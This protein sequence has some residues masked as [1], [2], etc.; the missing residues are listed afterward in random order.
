MENRQLVIIGAGPAGLTAAIYGRRAG[1]GVL[2]LERG[3]SGGQINVTAEIENYPG[4]KHAEGMELANAFRE[5]A[6]KF[7]AEFRDC[8]V[9]SV[10]IDGDVKT[11]KTNEGDIEADA[12]IIASGASF[13][14]AGC[15]GERE[16]AG[17][18]VSY[19][20]VCDGAFYE[21]APV[22][23]IGGGN[24]ALDEADFLT[25]FASKVY[26]IHRREE[27]RAHK[28]AVDLAA[29][30]PKI[31]RVMGFI[32]DEIAG[33]DMVERVVARN[34]KSGEIREIEVKGVFVFV[35]TS[36]NTEFLNGDKS[37]ERARGG[38]IVTDNKME[39]SAEGVFAAGDVRDKFLR[40]V[41]TA[42]GDGATAGMAAYEYIFHQHRLKS[43]L[44]APE[45]VTAFFMSSI[46][47]EHLAI[48]SQIDS[49]EK[50]GEEKIVIVDAHRNLRIRKKLDIKVLPVVVE[51]SRGTKVREAVVKTF[52][53]IINF[54]EKH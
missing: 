33:G 27:F 42:A 16:F 18:G 21:D 7:G 40:Q 54:R 19:C 15:K 37:I 22:A 50:S 35:G 6:E 36:P 4:F 39:T 34:L 12:L 46:D 14:R 5:H 43:T 41:V 26:I 13:S 10:S 1:I 32:V 45:H 17:R 31:E 47:S 8:E 9:K 2:L 51:F 49:M 48:A 23:V 3:M 28:S 30:N 38:W 44:L 20:A 29:A 24:T 53:D 52:D 11:V 25:H